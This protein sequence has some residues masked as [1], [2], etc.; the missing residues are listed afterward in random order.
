MTTA[1]DADKRHDAATEAD[2][3]QNDKDTIRIQIDPEVKVIELARALATEG[4][5]IKSNPETGQL[6]ITRAK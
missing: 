3:T 4:L 1:T 6:Y 5:T 2:M